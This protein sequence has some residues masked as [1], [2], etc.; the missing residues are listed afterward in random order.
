[1]N[2]VD[3]NRPPRW[4]VNEARPLTLRSGGRLPRS[5]RCQRFNSLRTT[6]FSSQN[7]CC[8]C[9]CHEFSV[10]TLPNR[11]KFV[12]T[13]QSSSVPDFSN[14]FGLSRNTLSRTRTSLESPVYSQYSK[15][16]HKAQTSHSENS[17]STSKKTS[18]SKMSE[19][20]SSPVVVEIESGNSSEIY[21]CATGNSLAE[22]GDFGKTN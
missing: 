7:K 10:T 13:Q 20:S 18:V 11:K 3:C 9:K 2:P 16:E 8:V 6:S 17:G 14:A 4:P 22:S 15:I 5:S 19:Q 12:V 21:N 1:M